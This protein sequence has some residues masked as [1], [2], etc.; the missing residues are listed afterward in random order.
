MSEYEVEVIPPKTRRKRR[1]GMGRLVRAVTAPVRATLLRPRLMLYGAAAAFVALL[2]TP[3]V[4]WDYECRH[5]FSASHPCRSVSYCAYYGVQGRRVE[6]PAYGDT[7]KLVTLL[8]PD[9]RK[10]VEVIK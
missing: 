5:P 9:W 10:L 4:G 6:F 8:P 7:C 3:H 2:G 1:D